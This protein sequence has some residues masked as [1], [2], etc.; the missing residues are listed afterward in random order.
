MYNRM[1]PTIT[2]LVDQLD[3]YSKIDFG[4]EAYPLSVKEAALIVNAIK[5]LSTMTE[6]RCEYSYAPP[7]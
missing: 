3:K 5:T 7:M 1:N 4:T 2:E 6:D